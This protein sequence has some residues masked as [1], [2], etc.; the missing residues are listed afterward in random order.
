MISM[1][2]GFK[3]K[4]LDFSFIT[5]TSVITIKIKLKGFKNI[6]ELLYGSNSR[7]VETYIDVD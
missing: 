7:R 1:K 3:T 2:F 6:T 5:S 4:N